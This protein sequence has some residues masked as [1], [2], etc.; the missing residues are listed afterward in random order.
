LIYENGTIYPIE[1]KKSASPGKK[2]IKNFDV[3]EPV[4]EPEKFGG[5]KE[6]K[7]EIG[8]GSVIC[9]ANDLLP[10]NEKNWIVPIWLI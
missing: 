6:L 1:I 10:I 2:A 9:I 8:T 4:T 7:I 3:L 5:L